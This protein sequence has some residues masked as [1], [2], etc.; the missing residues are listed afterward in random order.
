M[1]SE[2]CLQLN[3]AIHVV[4]ILDLPLWRRLVSAFDLTAT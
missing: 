3:A 4:E 1:A 2:R